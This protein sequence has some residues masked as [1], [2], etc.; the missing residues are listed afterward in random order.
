M[1]QPQ[2]ADGCGGYNGP[3]NVTAESVRQAFGPV[4]TY[5]SK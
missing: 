3:A 1:T 5:V 2:M 4:A